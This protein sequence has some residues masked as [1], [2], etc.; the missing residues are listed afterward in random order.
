M[1]IKTNQLVSERYQKNPTLAEVVS[2]V[3]ITDSAT[4]KIA[5]SILSWVKDTVPTIIYQTKL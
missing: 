3:I 1:V 5:Q 2:K 4:A